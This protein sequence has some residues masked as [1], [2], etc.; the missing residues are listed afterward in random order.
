MEVPTFLINSKVS[1]YSYP[2]G[3]YIQAN[4]PLIEDC[5]NTFKR[6]EEFRDQHIKLLCMGS[7]G[8]IIAAIF[9]SLV[10]NCTIIHVKKQG[11]QSHGENLFQVSNK[12]VNVIID[13]FVNTGKTINDI[14]NKV[15][16]YC[17][18]HIDC[19]CLRGESKHQLFKFTPDY[20]VCC[21]KT[22]KL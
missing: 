21:Y 20:I 14:Y 22:K 4:L 10:P 17:G 9:A 12:G 19:V 11:E 15:R 2:I 16:V 8:A 13:D 7:S 6:I 5:V 1:Y 3:M 18:E